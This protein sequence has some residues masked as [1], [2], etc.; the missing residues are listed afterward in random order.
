MNLRILVTLV[1]INFGY[2][3]C[4]QDSLNYQGQQLVIRGLSTKS[5]TKPPLF[6]IKGDN[7]VIQVEP[8]SN[9]PYRRRIKRIFKHFNTD[10]V[11]SIR[12]LKDKS[13]TELYGSLGKYGVA[14]ITL[15]S[16]TFDKL[17]RKLKKYE[18]TE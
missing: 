7:R 18:I 16:G 4:G 15:K 17:P 1:L 9:F 11:D 14:I 13:A 6:I 8:K 5:K 10:W 2:N 3:A 12:I